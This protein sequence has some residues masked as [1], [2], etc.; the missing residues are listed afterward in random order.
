MPKWRELAIVGVIIGALAAF[1]IPNFIEMQRKAKRAEMPSNMNGLLV[2]ELSYQA[3]F[4]RFV[5][6]PRGTSCPA[7][8]AIGWG[9]EPTGFDFEI[10]VTPDGRHFTLRGH[11]SRTG[12]SCER[13][14]TSELICTPFAPG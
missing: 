11:S 2:A 5:A 8:G 14:D 13:T 7:F 12:Q 6:C 10:T 1:A 3:S 4:D 9:P